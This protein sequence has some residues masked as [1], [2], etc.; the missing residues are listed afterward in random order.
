MDKKGYYPWLDIV[1]FLAACLVM[2]THYLTQ[3]LGFGW[4]G[5]EIF[6]VISGLV[7][8]RSANIESA[9]DFARRRF[10]RLY[11]AVWICATISLIAL[12]LAG[13]TFSSLLPVY[14]ASLIL[15][16]KFG[17]IDGVYWTLPIEISFYISV[18]GLLYFR[19]ASWLPRLAWTLSVA[20]GAFLSTMLLIQ[21]G[22]LPGFK[23]HYIA[24]NILLLR[25]GCYFAL[26]I[27]LLLLSQEVTA[28]RIAGALFAT[29]FSVAQLTLRILR[30]P[31][32]EALF[33]WTPV[34]VWLIAVLLIFISLK[35][36]Q[37]D[38]PTGGKYAIMRR[39][40]LM[41]YPLYLVHSSVGLT[42][43]TWTIHDQGAPKVLGLILG[44]TLSLT[45]AW[46][47]STF[48]EPAIRHAI[49][50]TR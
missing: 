43:A 18:F 36:P 21:I 40:G 26:G 7:I 1:R 4:V 23:E 25:H 6:F 10:L 47:I 42:F 20:S 14:L 49:R 2:G 35:Y 46:L 33:S 37:P 50:R 32:A 27:W 39:L 34:I 13:G 15:L 22:L 9:A 24:M 28:T 31:G 29:V 44:V 11:P 48:G 41:T 5:A 17:E 16:P 19:R 8:S 12:L 30:S 3:T 45:L 38:T